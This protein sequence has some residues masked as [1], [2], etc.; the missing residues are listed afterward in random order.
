MEP[1]KQ[2]Q[3]VHIIQA[4]YKFIATPIRRPDPLKKQ[5]ILSYIP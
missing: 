3:A 5:K 4:T 1:Q 2:I